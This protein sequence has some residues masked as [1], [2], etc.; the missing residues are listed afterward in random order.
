MITFCQVDS[1][2][3]NSKSKPRPNLYRAI[4]VLLPIALSISIAGC[5]DWI[6]RPDP[7]PDTPYGHDPKS[8]PG[9]TATDEDAKSELQ[10]FLELDKAARTSNLSSDIVKYLNQGFGL[11]DRMCSEWFNSLEASRETS[12]FRQGTTALTGTMAGTLMA[13]FKSAPN[14]IGA[15]VAVFGGIDGWFKLGKAT[16]FLTPKLGTVHDKIQGLRDSMATDIKGNTTITSS[17]ELSYRALARYQDTCGMLALQRFVDTATDL[18]KYD[19]T[20]AGELDPATKAQLLSLSKQYLTDIAWPDTSADIDPSIWRQIYIVR[21]ETD[22]ATKSKFPTAG[23]AAQLQT[24]YK[25]ADAGKMA[26]ADKILAA[27]G[28]LLKVQ[29]DVDQAKKR[30]LE[31]Q[32]EKA[33]KLRDAPDSKRVQQIDLEESIA[34]SALAATLSGSGAQSGFGQVRIIS[35]QQ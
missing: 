34:L 13:L 11:S 28:S 7:N 4:C 9:K 15:A 27:I 21:F 29:K 33:A 19:Y 12:E 14:E 16:F 5:A 25:A 24:A 22:L 10:N 6:P 30:V 17:Y 26:D 2:T 35:T 31:I 8:T 3:R 32:G 20:P 23:I 1:T 18:A